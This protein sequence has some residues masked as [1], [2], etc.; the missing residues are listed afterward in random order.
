MSAS[1]KRTNA[2]LIVA[3]RAFHLGDEGSTVGALYALALELA[4]RLER[5][6]AKIRTLE[7]NGRPSGDA[8][9][10]PDEWAAKTSPRPYEDFD[11]MARTHEPL[12][13][14]DLRRQIA[15]LAQYLPAALSDI[16]AI[17][18]SNDMNA[19]RKR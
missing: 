14:E 5:A 4:D 17:N 6:E 9:L 16:N 2:Q 8:W 18:F 10:A 12:L 15:V 11:P 13:V 19:A 1:D 7:G 3:A